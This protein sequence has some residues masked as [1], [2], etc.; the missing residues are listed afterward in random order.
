MANLIQVGTTADFNNI[1]KKKVLAE[2]KELLISKVEGRYYAID[3]RCSHLGGDL[4]A[5]T[6]EGYIVTCPRHGSQFDVHNGENVRWLKGSGLISTIG[7][8]FK[9]P[10]GIKTYTVKVE[11]EIIYVEI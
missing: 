1:N 9:P 5:G 3:N 7:K 2:G 8:T 11:D 10:R 4:A 6:L